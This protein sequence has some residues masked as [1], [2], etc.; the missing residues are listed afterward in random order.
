MLAIAGGILWPQGEAKMFGRIGLTFDS[1]QDGLDEQRA[2][3][4]VSLQSFRE[5][6]G[7]LIGFIP[8][9]MPGYTVHDLT[10]LDALWEMADVIVGNEYHL[11]PAEAYVLGG[12]ILL[13]DAGMTVAAYVGGRPEIER[14]VEFSA[15]YA[16]ARAQLASERGSTGVDERAREA[17][18]VETL[19]VLHPL[20][21]EQLATQ[22]WAARDGAGEIF[23][24]DDDDLRVH[25]GQLIGRVAHSHHWD[26]ARLQREFV[27][28]LG[29]APGLPVDWSVDPL[30]IALILRCADAAHLDARRAPRLLFSLSRISGVS[31]AHWT[32]QGLLAKPTVADDKLVYTSTS[33]FG[34][35]RAEPWQL[36][37]DT[38]R[39][40]DGELRSADEVN[41]QKRYPRFAVDGVLGVGSPEQL[42]LYLRVTGWKPVSLNLQ[43]SNVSHLARTLGGK[44]LYSFQLAPLRELL[45]KAADSIE[46]RVALDRDFS[47]EDGRIEVVAIDDG[48]G[49]VLLEIKDN[50]VGMSERVLTGPLLDFG[51][52]F[53]KSADARREFPTLQSDRLSPRGRY[54]IGFFSVFMWADNVEVVSRVYSVSAA[55]T[56]VLHFREGLDAR[57][58]LRNADAAEQTMAWSTRVRLRIPAATAGQVLRRVDRDPFR[59]RGGRTM[60]N[61]FEG[62]AQAVK[63]LAATLPIRVEVV[64]TQGREVVSLP[65]WRAVRPD[66]FVR[67]FGDL[68]MSSRDEVSARFS[69]ALTDCIEGGRIAGR[70]FLLPAAGEHSS[71]GKLL[72]YDRGIFAG[73]Q[74]SGFAC[75]V[76]EGKVVNAARE[77]FETTPLKSNPDWVREASERAFA[78]CAHEGEQLAVQRSLMAIGQIAD[79]RPLFI[80]NRCVI[81]WAAL[82]EQCRTSP[83]LCVILMESPDQDVYSFRATE[84]LNIIYGL[85]VDVDQVYALVPMPGSVRKDEALEAFIDADRCVLATFLGS[86]RDAFGA[87]V[88]L[89]NW[90]VEREGYRSDYMVVE[91]RRV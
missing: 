65:D 22:R 86:I 27:A 10:H 33:D 81:S 55:E 73:A 45:Q 21:A 26:H 36:A 8:R 77:R 47:V 69:S 87:D 49:S 38:L 30:K 40:V 1:K 60:F 2:R 48:A 41:I 84:T 88:A 76:V 39:M 54:G 74:F 66:A 17:A 23:L 13:H 15:A 31:T 25:F 14:T 57:P 63:C 59:D 11:S 7:Q 58:I 18:L 5:R 72:V 82:L 56:N 24:I 67:F 85:S 51:F 91:F 70:A 35:D 42:A 46:A 3:L 44:D 53:W 80:K 71:N 62:W 29:A 68:L 43:V 12:A 19:R 89:R 4:K 32:F 34:I 83:R 16:A 28:P 52:S 9:D 64:S 90:V 50:G 61:H 79:A 6:V 75:G 20:K 37:F 78:L